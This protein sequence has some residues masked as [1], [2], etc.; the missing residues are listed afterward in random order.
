MGP[1]NLLNERLVLT[2]QFGAINGSFVSGSSHHGDRL[3]RPVCAVGEF[4]AGKIIHFHR[5]SIYT[6]Q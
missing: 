1:A 6:I 4:G 2:P 5:N 3:E